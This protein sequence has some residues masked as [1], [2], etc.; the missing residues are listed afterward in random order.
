[1]LDRITTYGAANKG[2]GGWVKSSA[3]KSTR[4]KALAPA[5]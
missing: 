5:R 1:M 2:L 3:S 4:A